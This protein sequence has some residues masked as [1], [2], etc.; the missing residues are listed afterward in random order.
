MR[1]RTIKPEFFK[2]EQLA[3]LSPWARLLFIGLWGLADR[4]GRLE[5]R[6]MRI[7]VEILPYDDE[8]DVNILLDE[9]AN[10]TQHFII[11]YEAEGKKVIQIRTFT[12][13]QRINGTEKDYPSLLPKWKQRGSGVDSQEGKDPKTTL[14]AG[15]K[16]DGSGMDSH[17]DEKLKEKSKLINANADETDLEAGRKQDG[18]G[19]EA[20]RTVGKE[21]KGKEGVGVE[22]SG[23]TPTTTSLMDRMKS[24]IRGCRM[25]Y[26]NLR[27]DLIENTL[28][29][30]PPELWEKSVGEFARDQ[31]RALMAENN[32]LKSLAG[33]LYYAISKKDGATT[34]S[35][36]DPNK[37]VFISEKNRRANG[38]A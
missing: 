36:L 3:E 29:D 10:H 24:I 4:D 1:I 31:E 34:A 11:R 25:E 32:P 27:D 37:R 22:G 8:Q 5:D 15:G 16:Q 28:K 26:R 23:P 33:Y 18:S 17:E 38:Q 6:P 2:D 30:A 7:K 21:R 14:E 19:M 12:K 13:H 20:T 9:L 35:A